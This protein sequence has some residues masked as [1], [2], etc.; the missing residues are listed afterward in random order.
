[1]GLGVGRRRVE[2]QSLGRG[3]PG[4]ASDPERAGFPGGISFVGEGGGCGG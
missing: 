2:R 4:K 1:M 3:S